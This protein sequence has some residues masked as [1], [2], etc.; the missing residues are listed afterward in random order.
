VNAAML[1]LTV[2]LALLGVLVVLTAFLPAPDTA[3]RAPS[4]MRRRVESWRGL[5]TRRNQILLLAGLA[6]GVLLFAVSGWV[7]TLIAVP[8]AV[9]GIPALLGRGNTPADISR[10]E[11]TEQWTRSLS[12][13]IASGSASIEQAIA[14]SVQSTPKDIAE[15][16]NR[17]AARIAARWSTEDALQQFANDLNDSTA[18]LVVA[19]LKLAAGVRGAGLATALEDLAQDVFDEVKA[20]RQVE[21]DRAKTRQVVQFVTYVTLALLVLLPFGNQFFAAYSTPTGQLLLTMWLGVYVALL[22]LIKKRTQTRK[23]PRILVDDSTQGGR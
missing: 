9:I 16:V 15:P 21:A 10:L 13:L 11:S 17:L 6:G 8:A 2:M 14:L 19:H 18:D 20:R 12:G 5:L 22:L 23:A 4:A 7:I 3:G 1:A